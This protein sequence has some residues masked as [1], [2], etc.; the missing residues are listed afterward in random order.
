MNCLKQK[1][2]HRDINLSFVDNVIAD[3]GREFSGSLGMWGG[4]MRQAW[5][6]HNSV[7]RVPYGAPPLKNGG[8]HSFGSRFGPL[9]NRA[10]SFGA[11]CWIPGVKTERTAKK[12][13]KAGE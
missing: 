9:R 12:R 3:A 5:I 8:D 11:T 1:L 10:R 4:F 2:S 7:C 6:V 13:R